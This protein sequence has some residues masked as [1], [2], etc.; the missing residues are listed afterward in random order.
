MR[1]AITVAAIAA[2]L[3][4]AAA[5][6]AR[7]ETRRI[8]VIVGSN[9]GDASHAVLRYAEQDAAKLS[10]VLGELGGLAPA[11]L[12]LL[13]GPT[14]AAV[15]AALDEAARR[16]ARWHAE[17]RGQAVLLFYFSGHSDGQVLELSDQ[18]LAV[19][20]AATAPGRQRRADVRLVDCGQLPQRS[21]AG[22]Q[23]RDVGA[24]L[25]HPAGGRPRQHGR[26]AHRLQRRGRGG[27]GVVRDRR[28]VLL[29]SLRIGIAR[30]GPTSTAGDGLVTLAE[31]FQY[32]ASRTLRATSD[33]LVGPQHAAYD[34][35]LA[36]RGDLVLTELTHPSAVLDLPPDFDRLLLVAAVREEAIAELGPRSARRIAVPAGTYQVQGWRSG[37]R[38][39]ARITLGQRQ[40]LRLAA[41]DLVPV[42]SGAVGLKGGG[43]PEAVLASAAD[44]PPEASDARGLWSLS[45]AVGVGEGVARDAVLGM[46]RVGLERSLTSGRVAL[47][48]LGGTANADGLRESRA[49][50]ELTPSW[51]L[52]RGRVRLALGVS[53]GG[54]LAYERTD[55]GRVH[56]CG[57]GWVGPTVAVDARL[58]RQTAVALGAGAPVTLLRRD[59]HLTSTLLPSA[60]LGVSRSF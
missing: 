24:G 9:H 5:P 44:P 31:A 14:V 32:A 43:G 37:R 35:H 7:A 36:G 33:T 55:G 1:A 21:I 18:A 10:T 49:G 25:R 15:R 16:V 20:G 41:S 29:A 42:S 34:Y 3:I 53:V 58:D 28:L 47:N 26:G 45:G 54:G 17:R 59:D 60:W 46:L 40:E 2:T 56:F 27:P 22:A 52:G 19:L 30:R 12:L 6:R 13:R 51:W 57:L 23:R 8:A 39:G 38:F 48:V 11:D 50:V 4:T